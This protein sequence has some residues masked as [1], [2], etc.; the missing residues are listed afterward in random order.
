MAVKTKRAKTK[1]AIKPRAKTLSPKIIKFLQLY[2]EVGN[3][4]NAW[5]QAGNKVDRPT[6]RVAACRALQ[7]AEVQEHFQK[8]KTEAAEH[9]AWNRG[10]LLD[11]FAEIATNANVEVK[12]RLNAL[13][14]IG[15][16]IGAYEPD[17]VN[18]KSDDLTAL[19]KRIRARDDKA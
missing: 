14:E 2:L 7:R 17:E 19:L 4:P 1:R 8:L 18:V 16:M 13:K 11:E 3:R 12:D 6:A 9:H 15:R 5:I 10:M